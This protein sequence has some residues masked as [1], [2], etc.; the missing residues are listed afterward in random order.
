VSPSFDHT[1]GYPGGQRK[2]GDYYD[3]ISD[4][5]GVHVAYAATFNGEQDIYYLRIIAFDCNDNGI[6]DAD[7]IAAGTSLDCN[8]NTVQDECELEGA[9][10]NDN[11]VL[12]SCDI[13]EAPSEDCQPNGILDECELPG[14]DCNENSI[15][16]TCDVA[17]HTSLD[18][19]SNQVPDECE[20]LGND[21][22]ASGI[23]DECELAGNDC[24]TNGLPDECDLAGSTSP[25]CQPNGVPD[26]CELGDDDCDASGVPDDCEL[27]GNDCNANGVLDECELAGNDCNDNGAI[28]ACDIAAHSSPDCQANGI[29]DECELEGADCNRNGRPDECDLAGNDCDSS[30]LPDECEL[31]G[32]DCNHNYALDACDIATG[33]SVDCQ[34]NGLPDECEVVGNDCNANGRP[35]ECDL[36][37]NDCNANSKPDECDIVTGFSTDCQPNGLPDECELPGHDCNGNGVPDECELSGNDCNTNGSPDECD[38]AAGTSSDC[39]PNG[40]PDECELVQN[41]CNINGAPDE[42]DLAGN[43]CNANGLPDECELS[44]GDCNANGTLDECDI[45]ALTSP[46]CQPNGV[47]DECELLGKDC[48]TNDV[49]DDCD[50]AR[51]ASPDDN[52]NGIPDEC[53]PEPCLADYSYRLVPAAADDGD[54]TGYSVAISGGV[55]IVGAYGD[56]DHGSSSGSAYVFR[57]D[58]SGWHEEAHLLPADVGAGDRFGWSVD[59]SGEVALIGAVYDADQVTNSGSAYV[60]RFDG[61]HWIQEAKLLAEDGA[62]Y[63]LFGYSVA[64]SGNTLVVGARYEDDAG[65]NAGAAYVFGFDGSRWSQHAK[66]TA[67]DGARDDFFGSAVAIAGDTVV[68][69]AP[70]GDDHGTA[71]G[72][73]YV[74]H[75]NGATWVESAKLLSADGA[76]GDGF[77]CA[78]DVSPGLTVVGAH[79]ASSPAQNSGAA[80][81]FSFTGGEWVQ[82]GKLSAAD[83][84]AQDYFG[85]SVATS[86]STV[87]VGAEGDDD[88]GYNAGVAHVFHFDGAKWVGQAKA[89][90]ADGYQGDSLGFSVGLSGG[91]AVVGA[92]Y[93]RA[94]GG[95]RPGMAYIF[96]GLTDCNA[97]TGLDVCDIVD[98]ISEDADLNGIPDECS[99]GEL[100]DFNRD[101]LIDLNDLPGFAD[102]ATDPGNTPHPVQATVVRC[103]ET[104]DFDRDT[105]VDLHDY[106]AFEAGF[107]R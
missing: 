35:D 15:P 32:H 28:D 58:G 45:F 71:S 23:P 12:D 62:S 21:C 93:A 76:A 95:E 104:F 81:L 19:Q 39:Q 75:S 73:A 107:T 92:Y 27:A 102:C 78:V 61:A 6:A 94:L 68:I 86:G 90:A 99:G 88:G 43:D 52:G 33:A 22:N 63:D 97:N 59:V 3:T 2:L 20:L 24:N 69:G 87:V 56:D 49:P 11:G 51:G 13:A 82:R 48:N 16:D 44:A 55:A 53:E 74:Y 67:S 30:G 101:G 4:S 85:T 100:G 65:S 103:L 77:G 8:D 91:T 57:T 105:D 26:E 60:F 84:Q 66:L 14:N 46:D 64:L 83:G 72:S 98:G 25:D 7:D 31:A 106:L 79:Y 37:G 80:Y 18:C 9:D 54:Y 29:P 50:I 41:D 70:G 1:L 96:R 10:C 38:V 47:P 89:L 5:A 36:P 17:A 34:P 40:L 42:C